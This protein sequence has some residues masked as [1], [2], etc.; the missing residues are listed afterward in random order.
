MVGD[1]FYSNRSKGNGDCKAR[2]QQCIQLQE[3]SAAVVTLS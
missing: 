1:L 3:L 2:Y